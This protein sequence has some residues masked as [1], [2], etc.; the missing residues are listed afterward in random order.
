MNKLGT[1]SKILFNTPV[2][3]HAAINLDSNYNFSIYSLVDFNDDF[4]IYALVVLGL[5]IFTTPKMMAIFKN[6]VIILNRSFLIYPAP[7]ILND[8]YN[9]GIYTPFTTL[10]KVVSGIYSR[11]LFSQN[12][13][14]SICI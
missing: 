9:L 11:F 10:D 2:T 12:S 8:N 1:T 5:Q 14:V 13:I 3:I 6:T 7:I 4:G